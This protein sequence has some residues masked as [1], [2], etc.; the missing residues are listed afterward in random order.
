MEDI[1]LFRHQSTFNILHDFVRGREKDL[2]EHYKPR[3]KEG[4][5]L[6]KEVAE[7]LKEGKYNPPV[8]SEQQVQELIA[9]YVE[10]IHL[11]EELEKSPGDTYKK[12][13]AELSCLERVCNIMA[14]FY[15]LQRVKSNS[16]F[17]LER[18]LY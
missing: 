5:K 3:I 17:G 14:D 2:D 4:K 8:L 6:I 15:R 18:I 16:E 13:E 12:E 10:T 11:L 9:G 1:E 7:N